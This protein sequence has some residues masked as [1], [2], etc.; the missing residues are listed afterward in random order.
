MASPDYWNEAIKDLSKRDK[1]MK[2]II[3]NYEGEVMQM[4]GEAFFTLARSIVG[5]QISVNAADSVWKRVYDAAGQMTPK[6]VANMP[7]EDLRACGLS[8][9]K[10]IYMHA[11]AN[12]FLENKKLI[13]KWPDMSDADIIKELTEIKGIGRWTAEMFLIFH[14]GRP[15]IFPVADIGLQKAV[16]RHYNKEQPMTLTELRA[17]GEDWAPWRSVATWYMWRSLDPVPVAY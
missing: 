11:L 10:V 17:K 4:R 3:S 8:A 2:H 5:Q 7:A 12:H 6:I 1:V 14:L 9:S 15:D 16:F 13:A